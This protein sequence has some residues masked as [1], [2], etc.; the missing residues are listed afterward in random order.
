MKQKALLA[1]VLAI[2][3]ARYILHFSTFIVPVTR[4]TG[5]ASMVMYM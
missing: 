2:D 4:G 3:T 1:Y 5:Q